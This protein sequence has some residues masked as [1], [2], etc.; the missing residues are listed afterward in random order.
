MQRSEISQ[1]ITVDFQLTFKCV[2]LAKSFSEVPYIII[3]KLL[4]L[5]ALVI[6]LG[7]R[8]A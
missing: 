5:L 8:L 7:D 2:I 1:I 4:M 6:K 3:C